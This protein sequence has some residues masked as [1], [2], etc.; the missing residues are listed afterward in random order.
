[1]AD[2]ISEYDEQEV[3]LSGIPDIDSGNFRPTVELGS[4]VCL[5]GIRILKKIFM[6]K[7]TLYDTDL[8]T[9]Y[10]EWNGIQASS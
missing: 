6:I 7:A 9:R 4:A 3:I 5:Q 1:M 8:H 2:A 10:N